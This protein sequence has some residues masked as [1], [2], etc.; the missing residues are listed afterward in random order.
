MT[1]LERALNSV[2]S[3]GEFTW[4]FAGR[5]LEDTF[6]AK[7]AASSKAMLTDRRPPNGK[8]PPES[9]TALRVACRKDTKEQ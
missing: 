9:V 8:T 7:E 5:C 2:T 4:Q 6:H 1:V 3:A